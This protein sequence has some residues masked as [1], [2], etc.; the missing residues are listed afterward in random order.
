MTK[1]KRVHRGDILKTLIDMWK[2]DKRC[3]QDKDDLW[4]AIKEIEKLRKENFELRARII[5]MQ[6]VQ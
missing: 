1:H 6:P 4:R 5:K 3:G 2:E